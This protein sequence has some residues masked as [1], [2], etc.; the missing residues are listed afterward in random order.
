M[1]MCHREKKQRIDKLEYIG[2]KVKL[3]AS[4]CSGVTRFVI[5]TIVLHKY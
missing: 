1:F 2:F 5:T 3:Y 4:V